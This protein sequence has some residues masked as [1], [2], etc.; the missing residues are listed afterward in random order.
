MANPHGLSYQPHSFVNREAELALIVDKAKRMCDRLLVPSSPPERQRVV[1]FN[2][3]RG[4]G[5]SWLLQEATRLLTAQPR[6]VAHY[7]DLETLS[8][9]NPEQILRDKVLPDLLTSLGAP[10]PPQQSVVNATNHLI[11]KLDEL[12]E[13]L[14][15]VLIDHLDESEKKFLDMLDNRCLSQLTTRPNALLILAERG[16]GHTWITLALRHPPLPLQRFEARHTQEQLTRQVPEAAGAA[17]DIQWRSNGIPLANL[18]YGQGMAPNPSAP[19]PNVIDT[20]LGSAQPLRRRFEA[21]CVL[22]AFDELRMQAM[23]VEYLTAPHDPVWDNL[24]CVTA[25]KEL[26]ATGLVHWD[27]DK[28]GYVIDDA[29]R[30]ILEH[31]L[32]ACDEAAWRHLH[33]AAYRLYTEWA[34]SYPKSR[35]EWAA[36]A[37]YH[38]DQIHYSAVA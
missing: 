16:K 32:H 21:L 25:R 24:A 14:L 6:M 10:L 2:A 11:L 19:P 35:E 1:K 36:E 33:E 7:L 29:L 23:F 15:V 34:N 27:G 9:Q 13:K 17:D 38:D 4:M 31:E 28:R 20:L 3:E 22:R 12:S 37:A 18:L 5:K 8:K 26:V 30:P